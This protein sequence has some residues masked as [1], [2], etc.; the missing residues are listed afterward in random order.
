MTEPVGNHPRKEPSKDSG[1]AGIAG[2]SH[3]NR[4]AT[5]EKEPVEKIIEGKVISRK[6]PWY[7][8]F[9]ENM[10]A[11]DAGTVGEYL[12]TDVVIPATKNLIIDM[13]SQGI[14]KVLFGTARGRLRR[15]PIGSSLRDQFDYGR[16]SRDREPRRMMSR[17]ARATHNFDSIVLEHRSDAIDVVEAL[18]ERIRRYGSVTVAEL[19]DLVGVSGSYT[20]RR[21]GW[22]DLEDADVRQMPGGF[23]LDLPQPELIR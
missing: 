5:P 3:K 22:T 1:M 6:T 11:E 12:L 21:W 7:K 15:S 10:L 4:D 16:V 8:R 14:E 2:N 9:R 19:Y 13:V 17:E 18:V 23:L 20:D